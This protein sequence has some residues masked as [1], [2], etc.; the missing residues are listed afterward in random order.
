MIKIN[1]IYTRTGD[2]GTTGLVR[3]P[4]RLKY[5]LRVE[6]YG[7]I[8][9]ANSFIAHDRDG[10]VTAYAKGSNLK[11]PRADM[12]EILADPESSYS[13]TP[14]GS[15]V[16]ASFLARAGVVKA[17]PAAWTDLFLPDIHGQGG[18]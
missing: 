4:R 1:R 7:T 10:A 16:Y 6:C 18:N 11:M 12:L 13:T 2:D 9:E 3:G 17:K 14:K 5:D 8:D 15:L